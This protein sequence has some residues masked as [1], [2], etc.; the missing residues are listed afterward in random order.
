MFSCQKYI[1]KQLQL[2]QLFDSE[3][4]FKNNLFI[5]LLLFLLEEGYGPSFDRLK[6]HSLK[7]VIWHND[8]G[9]VLQTLL[10]HR[11]IHSLKRDMVLNLN[12]FEFPQKILC[13]MFG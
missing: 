10:F 9:E 3:K 2:Y 4:N 1:N 8:T 13:A 7:D 11:Y 12:K 5:T 6:Y